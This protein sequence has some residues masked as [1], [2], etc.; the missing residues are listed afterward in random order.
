MKGTIQV[1]NNG[2]KK[3]Y[4][5]DPFSHKILFPNNLKAVATSSETDT[6]FIPEKMMNLNI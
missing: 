1:E 2:Y 5:I 4:K 3:M 6:K